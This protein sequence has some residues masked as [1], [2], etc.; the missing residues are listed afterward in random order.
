MTV[1]HLVR[2]MVYQVPAYR[3]PEALPEGFTKLDANESPYGPS[4]KVISAIVGDLRFLNRYPAD[5]SGLREKIAEYTRS[6]PDSILIGNGS[7]EILELLAKAFLN[8]GDEVVVSTPSFQMYEVF[9]KLA[10]ADVR[11]VPMREGFRWDMEGLLSAAEEAKMI[12]LCSPNNPTGNALA[13]REA[14]AMA[15]SDAIVVV[16]EAYVEFA[17]RSLTGLAAEKQN[18]VFLRTFS[19][20]FALAGLRVGYAVASPEAIQV[21]NRVKAPYN[22]NRLALAAA[23]AALEDLDHMRRL[24]ELTKAARKDLIS[25]LQRLEGVRVYS[26]DANFLLLEV[27][28]PSRLPE[29]LVT[30]LWKKG[31]A[32][33][34]CSRMPGLDGAYLRVTVGTRLENMRLV[35]CLESILEDA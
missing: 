34:D 20:A 24:V 22:V 12:L 35:E 16:D 13:E 7:D 9:A 33:R 5:P 11:A 14:K 4:P 6:R 25:R 27:R 3:D 18:L 29:S 26:S 15:E 8:P 21:L 30:A 28:Q 17:E 31:F 2:P 10:G 1:T 23:S 19:K 32:V